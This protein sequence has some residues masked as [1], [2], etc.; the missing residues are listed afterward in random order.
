[1]DYE[2]QEQ[3]KQLNI[4]ILDSMKDISE[5][6]HNEL[7]DMVNMITSATT[8]IIQPI[9]D[10]S[11]LI[12]RE[13]NFFTKKFREILEKVNLQKQKLTFQNES[14]FEGQL[15]VIKTELDKINYEYGRMKDCFERMR[16]ITNL[17]SEIHST[18][19]FMTLMKY[20]KDLETKIRFM[21]FFPEFRG[22]PGKDEV[23][24]EIEKSTPVTKRDN[25]IETYE[26]ANHSTK[27]KEYT[28]QVDINQKSQNS[29]KPLQS[30]RSLN[31]EISIPRS[32][33]SV[34][35]DNE[36]VV[37]NCNSYNNEQ[38]PSGLRSVEKFSVFSDDNSLLS[39]ADEPDWSEMLDINQGK[40]GF[41]GRKRGREEN[42]F[43][44]D[45]I[46]I[47]SEKK[48]SKSFFLDSESKQKGKYIKRADRVL[49]QMKEKFPENENILTKTY[50][51]SLMKTKVL[52]SVITPEVQQLVIVGKEKFKFIKLTSSVSN[53]A[54]LT[55][56]STLIKF[57][58]PFFKH[59]LLLIDEKLEKII[60][61]GELISTENFNHFI[62][63]L[64]H[65]KICTKYGV[66]TLKLECY[67]HL[68]ELIHSIE[69][70]RSDSTNLHTDS[71]INVS[72]HQF[73]AD[74]YELL[75]QMRKAYLEIC[76]KEKNK[77]FVNS[78]DK[79]KST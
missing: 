17:V 26:K 28:N 57:F 75:N 30:S 39:E 35:I 56:E 22:T 44:D 60:I 15:E 51:H 19:K 5:K 12:K 72:I 3:T 27:D 41:S 69:S 6:N 24:S 58:K 79:G 71:N 7:I 67:Q 4:A 33:S 10:S 14:N 49:A 52:E 47:F 42:S 13:S 66:S 16:E 2:E 73:L 74:Q 68:P 53:I 21:N 46:S 76:S 65:E 31:N 64:N 54:Q 61:G 48:D 32:S 29:T 62:E 11:D 1:M 77:K 63:I 55:S 25:N 34:G 8:I 38:A 50:L 45:K 18:E 59:Y 43:L 9:S 36:I 20:L 70:L 78:A 23:K 37:N 40:N